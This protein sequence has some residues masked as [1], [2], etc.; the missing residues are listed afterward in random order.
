MFSM[1]GWISQVD[2]HFWGQICQ[3]DIRHL[4]YCNIMSCWYH[5]KQIRLD[6]TPSWG[7]IH[8]TI[9]P[10]RYSFFR[11][12]LP[13]RYLAP[14]LLQYNVL[15]IPCQTNSFGFDTISVGFDTLLRGNTFYYT[16]MAIFWILSRVT[17]WSIS[18]IQYRPKKW[19]SKS[20]N[21]SKDVY[22]RQIC[23]WQG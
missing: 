12:N 16:S 6:L 22:Y 23:I 17:P 9:H 13:N 5:V 20:T 11:L 18:D 21:P 8:S 3:I 10:S 1:Q 19:R 7:A 15:L 14:C 4:V 2:I